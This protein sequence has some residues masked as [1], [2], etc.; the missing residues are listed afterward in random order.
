MSVSVGSSGL[1]IPTSI[2]SEWFSVTDAWTDTN[3]GNASGLD[4]YSFAMHGTIIW[5]VSS[6]ALILSKNSGVSLAKVG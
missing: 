6:S 1:Q 5:S 3:Y 2:V 4:M